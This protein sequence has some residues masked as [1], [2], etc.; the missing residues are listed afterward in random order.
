MIDKIAITAEE[1]NEREKLKE[2]L[3]KRVDRLDRIHDEYQLK[4]DKLTQQRDRDLEICWTLI[5]QDRKK[6][7][8]VGHNG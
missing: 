8:E 5:D 6:L 2:R 4:I 7:Q 3:R 1:W